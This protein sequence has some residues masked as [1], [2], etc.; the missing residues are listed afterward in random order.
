MVEVC[1]GMTAELADEIMRR[2]KAGTLS[3]ERRLQMILAA[4]TL[5]LM[6]KVL[7]D[8]FPSG[9]EHLLRRSAGL[10]SFEH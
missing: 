1:P 10:G 4:R 9:L 2:L 6:S 8:Q 3:R 5:A 7:F